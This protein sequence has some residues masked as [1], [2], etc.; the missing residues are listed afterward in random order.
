VLVDLSGGLREGESVEGLGDLL[1]GASTFAR[2]LRRDENSRLH[3]LGRGEGAIEPGGDLDSVVTA[4]SR[5]YDFVVLLVSGGEDMDMALALAAGADHCFVATRGQGE[6]IESL[7]EA[8]Y[9]SGAAA[10]DLL[11]VPALAAEGR[12]RRPARV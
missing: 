8:L 3:I 1:D 7:Q 5:T 10:V 9:E 12:V 2:A 11:P 6:S 4:L